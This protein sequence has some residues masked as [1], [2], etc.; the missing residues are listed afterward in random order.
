MSGA[1]GRILGACGTLL[2]AHAAAA[3]QAPLPDSLSGR[4]AITYI[5]GQSVYIGAGVRD[6][7]WHGSRVVVLRQ[8]APIAELKVHFLSSHSAACDVI[9]R[10]HSAEP[11]RQCALLEI[12]AREHGG[13]ERGRA[14]GAARA[15][16]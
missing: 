10:H 15:P 7:V 13:G 4:A 2:L 14:A 1:T 16:A 9:E 3:Q 11:L 5:T 6:G 12:A 8:G